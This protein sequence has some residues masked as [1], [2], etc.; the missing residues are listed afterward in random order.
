[1]NFDNG[2][3]FSMTVNFNGRNDKH[4]WNDYLKIDD[5]TPRKKPDVITY[6]WLEEE[7]RR[8]TVRDLK[9][10]FYS[11]NE[12][13]IDSLADVNRINVHPLIL[14]FDNNGHLFGKV[15]YFENETDASLNIMYLYV[16]G[17]RRRRNHENRQKYINGAFI[18]WYFAAQMAK[19]LCGNLSKLLIVS[20]RDSIT[21]Y[22]EMLDVRYVEIVG[23]GRDLIKY[24]IGDTSLVYH[25]RTDKS[26]T[27][28]LF[29][30]P[31]LMMDIEN[32]E[33]SYVI[34]RRV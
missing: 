4:T 7:L 2:S 1:M 5:A 19:K 26:N 9:D 30:A 12:D 22:L 13:M 11:K 18:V 21:K 20:P 8:A 24:R 6:E 34:K 23:E 3:Y 16:L 25:H 29:Y 17:D 15:S 28:A 33:R 14:V 27:G 10:D 32:L 31:F